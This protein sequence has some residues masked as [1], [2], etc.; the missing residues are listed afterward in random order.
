MADLP[1]PD[2]VANLPEDESVR[3]E[4]APIIPYYAPAQPE[5]YV[6]NINGWLIEDDDEELEEDGVDEDDDEELEQDGVGDGEE[7]EME[8]DD[9]MDDS[10]VINPYEI[11]EGEL[12]PPP[13]EADTSSNIEPEVEVEVENEIEAATVGTITHAPYHV[14]PF[15]GTT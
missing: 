10:K 9:E 3:P 14:H 7:K 2:H 1:P 6:G 4:P 5:G 15:M 13:A 8:I 11:E 12:P